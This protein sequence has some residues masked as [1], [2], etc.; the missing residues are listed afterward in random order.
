M[1]AKSGGESVMIPS[2]Q[3]GAFPDHLRE[4]ALEAWA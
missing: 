1:S 4:Y 2:G 3:P